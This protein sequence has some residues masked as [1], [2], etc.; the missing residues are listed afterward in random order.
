MPSNS[1]DRILF[2]NNWTSFLERFGKRDNSSQRVL[3]LLLNKYG[4][5]DR[6]YHSCWHINDAYYLLE[7]ARRDR[8]EWFAEPDEDAAIYLALFEHDVIY[9][10]AESDNE[11]RSATLASAH[12]HRLGFGRGVGVRV[13]HYIRATDHRG[14]ASTRGAQIVCDV[15]LATLAL[16]WENFCQKTAMVREE[17]SHIASDADFAAGRRAF[18]AKMLDP[19]ARPSIYQT[20][21]FARFEK[22]ARENLER[23]VNST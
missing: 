11:R 13:I 14:L 4:G 9:N 10:A 17:Y 19:A 16:P 22:L 15:D 21:Y 12:A 18:F 1:Y 20:E 8:P 5:A 3:P 2:G 23:V 6:H 7:D